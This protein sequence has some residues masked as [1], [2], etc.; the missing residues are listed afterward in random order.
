MWL[1]GLSLILSL[2]GFCH[3]FDI[4]II[5]KKLDSLERNELM[6]KKSLKFLYHIQLVYAVAF[7]YLNQYMKILSNRN[8]R[9]ISCFLSQ[10]NWFK[11]PSLNKF[12][13][14]SILLRSE[15]LVELPSFSWSPGHRPLQQ[16]SVSVTPPPTYSIMSATAF[17]L[18]F[19]LPTGLPHQKGKDIIFLQ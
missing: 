14:N 4:N 2:K 8:A 6:E 19:C 11:L 13:T 3:N 18:L 17:Y 7:Y 12:R 15:R 9:T 5:H 1:V 10:K 16:P